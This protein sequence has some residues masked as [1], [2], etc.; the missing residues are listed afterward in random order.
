VPAKKTTKAAVEKIAKEVG[1]TFDAAPTKPGGEALKLRP[2]R[3]ALWDSYGGSMPSGWI[4]WIFEQAY[5]AGFEVVF[6][7]A[8]DAGN[9]AAKYDVIIFPG[10]AIPAVAGEE[11]GGG[12]GGGGGGDFPGGGGAQ[13]NIPAEYQNRQGR[14]TAATTIPILK[15]FVE[16]GGTIIAIGSSTSIGGHFGLPLANGLVEMVGGV[17]R[18]LGNE[19]FYVPGSL[20]R[21]EVDNTNPLAYGLADAADVMW[22]ND[23]AYRLLPDALLKGVRP[24]GWFSTATPLRS[25]WAWGQ[26]YLKG[27]TA[28][29]DASV[30]KGKVFLLSPEVTFRAQP[31]NTFK[32]LFN[33]IYYGTAQAANLGQAGKGAK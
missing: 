6:P 22:E 12:R 18:R 32:L 15:K 9:L 16:E 11:G 4:R 27:L 33:G 24:V 14:V 2:T 20:L 23:P 13:A 10:G 30:G 19:K 3:I 29:I 8:L 26:Q 5:P 25:G 21:V 7:P 31:H 17:E 28:I 1:V